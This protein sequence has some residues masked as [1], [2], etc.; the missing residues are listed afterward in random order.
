[1]EDLIKMARA[2]REEK[3]YLNRGGVIVI[4]DGIVNGWVNT[5][6]NPDH[7]VPGCVA[8]D[9]EG[10]SWTTIAGNDREGALMWLP[11]DQLT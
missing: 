9:E 10:R 8:I 3:G 11:N 5:L 4:H 2:W 1:M 7:W 6:R